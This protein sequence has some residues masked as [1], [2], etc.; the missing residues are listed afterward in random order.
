M[1]A[2]KRKWDDFIGVHLRSFADQVFKKGLFA[3]FASTPTPN[4]DIA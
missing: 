4:A 2:N 3:K 1:N